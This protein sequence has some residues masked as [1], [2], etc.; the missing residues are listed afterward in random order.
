MPRYRIRHAETAA[1]K[2]IAEGI[3]RGD[4]A[5]PRRGERIHVGPLSDDAMDAVAGFDD[6]DVLD[7]LQFLSI[8]LW[9]SRNSSSRPGFTRKRTALKAVILHLH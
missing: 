5:R 4:H 1:L 9:A 6:V 7:T 3:E 2:R 8:F